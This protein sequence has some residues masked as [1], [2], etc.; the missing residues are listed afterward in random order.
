MKTLVRGVARTLLSEASYAAAR[1]SARGLRVLVYHR[2]SSVPRADDR[3]CVGS[4]AFA[5]QL[6]LIGDLGY[7][8]VGL[9]EATPAALAGRERAVAL[10][11]DDGYVDALNAVPILRGAD[12]VATFCLVP[13]VMGGT[14]TWDE[15]LGLV[16]SPIMGWEEAA[17]LVAN[18]M[19]VG[20]HSMT[21]RDLCGVPDAELDH[22]VRASK[23]AI[24]QRLG[25][26]VRVFSVPGG[27]DDA[28]L[29]A[30]LRR[31]SYGAKVTTALARREVS[32]GILVLPCIEIVQADTPREFAKKL[33]GAY[34]WR[35]SYQRRA[36]ASGR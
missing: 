34:D 14:S 31:A 3:W 22:E 21:H 13:G 27:G 16:P 15:A 18:G 30:A 4:D 23:S 24:E 2:V 10:V 36:A 28:R 29:N 25:C 26:E 9:P 20:S 33:V 19:R 11:F 17:T 1:R 5:T 35:Y 32:E 8:V 7:R 12:A 6:R